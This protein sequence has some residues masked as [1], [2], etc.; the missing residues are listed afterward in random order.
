M[1]DSLPENLVNELRI[2]SIRPS[3]DLQTIR[4]DLGP[5]AELAGSWRGRGFNLIGR[6]D[7]EQNANVFLE[8]N[9]TEETLKFDPISS[10]IPNRGFAQN[11]ISLFGLTYLQKITDAVT[12]GALHIEPGI[13][14]LQPD[15]QSP[16][17]KAGQGNALV[18]RMGSIPHGNAILA[19][20]LATPFSGPPC[21][22]SN[23]VAYNGSVFPSFNSTPF[24]VGGPIFAPGT[25]E[26][27]LPSPP[28]PAPAHGFA[29]YTLSDPAGD[30]NRTPA[31]NVPAIKLPAAIDGVA[32]QD[33]VN[34]PI[35]LLQARVQRQIDEGFS[36]DGVALNI[37]TQASIAFGTVANTPSSP[38][39]SVSAS[40]SGGGIENLPFLNT[41]AQ[42]ALIYATFWLTRMTHPHRREAIQELHYAQM[43]LLNYPILLAADPKPNF[44]WP[45]VSVATLHKDFG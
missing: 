18:A 31:G 32:M 27:G 7:R 25:S 35:R 19:E 11:D 17:E 5:L 6:P 16:P 22:P 23:G 26:F 24:A 13:W 3:H 10:S 36:F 12:G 38:T 15:T 41:N 30:P 2:P 4:E 9:Q 43:V 28:P 40:G 21:L 29:P 44:S 14:V 8:L 34:D 1:P 20:G 42:S 37:A 45:H 39:R 33:I